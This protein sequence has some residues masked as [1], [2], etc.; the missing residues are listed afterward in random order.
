MIGMWSLIQTQPARISRAA[1]CASE[2]T[3]QLRAFSLRQALQ[4]LTLD[5]L[6]AFVPQ[7]LANAEVVVLSHG[8]E[9]RAQALAMS[10]AIACRNPGCR[11]SQSSTTAVPSLPPRG[12]RAYW[13]LCG[14]GH[15]AAGVGTV[16][17]AFW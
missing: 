13:K 10:E 6:R 1:R 8:N 4:P 3:G 17:L 7:L 15:W 12:R 5:D 14:P 16:G 2:L 11:A 9:P